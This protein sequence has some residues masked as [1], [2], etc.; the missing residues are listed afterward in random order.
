MFTKGVFIALSD[1]FTI[2]FDSGN[3]FELEN[4]ERTIV[5]VLLISANL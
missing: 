1:K 3:D 5:Y 2:S 4:G